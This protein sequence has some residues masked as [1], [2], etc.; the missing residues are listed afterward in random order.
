MVTFWS[1][2]LILTPKIIFKQSLK[3][4][5]VI[6]IHEK[7]DKVLVKNY[8]PVHEKEDKVLVKNY[9][10]V[11][12]LPIFGKICER[13]ICNFLFN[14]IVSN[15]LFTF[16]IWFSS[17]RFMYCPIII[18]NSWNSS[19]FRWKSNCWCESLFRYIES[20]W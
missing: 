14:Y 20:L 6:P 4:A 16:P 12:S 19:C 1:Q 7:E 3:K 10:P 9:L 11:S 17:R 13:V 8:L 15:R 2:P 5:N 18:N